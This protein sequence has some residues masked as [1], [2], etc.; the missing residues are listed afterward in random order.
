MV[1]WEGYKFEHGA[2][3][4]EYGRSTLINEEEGFAGGYKCKVWCAN[5]MAWC[6]VTAYMY[7][8]APWTRRVSPGES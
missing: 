2:T 1:V 5:T 8:S 6:F 4:A 7:H 3:G